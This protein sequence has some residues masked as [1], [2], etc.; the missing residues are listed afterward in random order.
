MDAQEA[1][2]ILALKKTIF[3]ISNLDVSPVMPINVAHLEDWTYQAITGMVKYAP[4]LG[5]VGNYVKANPQASSMLTTHPVAA[6]QILTLGVPFS[7]AYNTAMEQFN[8]RA[9]KKQDKDHPLIKPLEYGSDQG[10]HKQILFRNS[11][12][13]PK[14]FSGVYKELYDLGNST[15]TDPSLDS[16]IKDLA[17]HPSIVYSRSHRVILKKREG[18]AIVPLKP[19]DK[20]EVGDI[21]TVKSIV[22]SH[23]M[24][25]S[26]KGFGLGFR[27]SSRPQ[28]ARGQKYV[29]K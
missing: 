28:T 24:G 19:E 27:L 8:A 16:V 11:L 12:C 9:K 1:S 13:T 2:N 20:I 14:R 23:N 25:L 17:D 26:N 6:M 3:S 10:N 29:W 15:P 7:N 22:T 21:V 5:D 4:L 18:D